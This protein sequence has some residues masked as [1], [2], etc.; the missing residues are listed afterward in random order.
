MPLGEILLSANDYG[1]I[2]LRMQVKL[3]TENNPLPQEEIV[4]F[5]ANK[6]LRKR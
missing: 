4:V 1:L 6:L 2:I 3:V 5:L